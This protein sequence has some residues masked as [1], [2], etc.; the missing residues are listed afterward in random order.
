MPCPKD[1]KLSEE[2]LPDLQ[3]MLAEYRANRTTWNT[4]ERYGNRFIKGLK[5]VACVVAIIFFVSGS[6]SD[7]FKFL[8][9]F[10]K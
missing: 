7:V 3:E 6:K 5:I 1:C 10:A 2:D 4:L 8:L 9:G